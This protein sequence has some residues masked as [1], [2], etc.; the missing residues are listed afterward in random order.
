METALCQLDQWRSAGRALPVSINLTGHHLQHPRFM[1]SLKAAL[2]RHPQLAPGQLELEV[3]ETSALED[4]SLVAHAITECAALGVSFALDDFG[5]GFSTLTYLK[6]LPAQTLKID[7][8]FI[9]DMLCDPEDL[10]IVQGVLGLASAFKRRAIA[11]GAETLAHCQMLLDIG[12]DLAQGY[13][14][15]RPMPAAD[16]PAWLDQWHSGTGGLAA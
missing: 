4:I 14:I 16:V 10:A 5:T 8:S 13:G 12:C 1:E 3:L 9:R 7:Q 15:A 2:A 11:E 6:R